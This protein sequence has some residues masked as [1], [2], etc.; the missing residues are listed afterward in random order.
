[1]SYIVYIVMHLFCIPHNNVGDN[2]HDMLVSSLSRWWVSGIN[3]NIILLWT[4]WYVYRF[5]WAS[6]MPAIGNHYYH[7]R[8]WKLHFKLFL[9]R[10]IFPVFRTWV[11]GYNRQLSLPDTSHSRCLWS[12][13]HGRSITIKCPRTLPGSPTH[14]SFL[15][16]SIWHVEKITPRN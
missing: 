15:L 3:F 12:H 2:L 13:I 6:Q 11:V 8:K 14:Y 16:Q 7:P 9:D 1:M 5:C 4:I 10:C